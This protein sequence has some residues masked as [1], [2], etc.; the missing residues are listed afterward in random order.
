MPLSKVHRV[1]QIMWCMGE[2]S[3]DWGDLTVSDWVWLSPAEKELLAGMRF[4]KRRREW[5]CGRWT[6]K[7]LLLRCSP[8]LAGKPLTVISIENHMHGNPVVFVEGQ[9]LPGCLS[10]S[11]RD[12]QA[13]A[14]YLADEDMFVGIDLERIEER[15]PAFLQDYFTIKEIEWVTAAPSHEQPLRTTLIWSA[16]EAALKSMR[17]GLAVDTRTVEVHPSGDELL[18]GWQ[19]L[20]FHSNL[21][22]E[23]YQLHG[24]WQQREHFIITIVVNVPANQKPTFDI[25]EIHL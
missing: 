23:G 15:H 5:L 18:H 7:Q 17:L 11:H 13:A 16:K 12:N 1:V 20:N 8:W 24:W 19:N 9:T 2:V 14:A 4:P 25:Q 21:P 10:L 6:A 22:E 3:P